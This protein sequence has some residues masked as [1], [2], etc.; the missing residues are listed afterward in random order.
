MS[1]NIH[2]RTPSRVSKSSVSGS[3]TPSRS[4]SRTPSRSQSRT[5]SRSQSRN[6]IR[7]Q[8]G[9]P[10]RSQSRNTNRKRSPSPKNKNNSKRV[11]ITPNSDFSENMSPMAPEFLT[12]KLIKPWRRSDKLEC[13]ETQIPTSQIWVQSQQQMYDLQSLAKY[14]GEPDSAKE[15]FSSPYPQ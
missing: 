11:Q 13:T 6:T 1:S 5:Q 4:Q 2:S 12:R 3:A 8:S 7:S 10:S 15:F 9:N 14:R